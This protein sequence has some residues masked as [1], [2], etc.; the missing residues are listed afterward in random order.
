MS[1][2]QIVSSEDVR[3]IWARLAAWRTDDPVVLAKKAVFFTLALAVAVVFFFPF[4]WLLKVSLV[5]PPSALYGGTPNLA[6]EEVSLFNF[7]R[8]FFQIDFLGFFWNSVV[9]AAV[10]SSLGLLTNTLTAYALTLEFRGKRIVQIL[11]IAFLMIPYYLTL[12][13]VFLITNELGL[14]NTRFG[15]ALVLS[16]LVIGILVLKDSFDAVPDSLVDAARLDGASEL[17][18]IFGVL[19]PVSRS[20]IA[21]N[22]ILLFTVSWNAYLLPAVLITEDSVQ[23][24]TM[25]LVNFRFTF[26][27]DFVAIY[28]FAIMVLAPITLVFLLLQ[29]QFIKS[30][31]LANIKG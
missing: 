1:K 16:V 25:A 4:Y 17:Y 27:A 2:N 9:I 13:P 14:L 29:R 20:A 30:V 5:W 31:V 7:V 11:L 6:L 10:A 12:I 15:V 8:V 3:R 28:A 23:P 18:I 21:T 26:Q 24:L 22:V 19:Y